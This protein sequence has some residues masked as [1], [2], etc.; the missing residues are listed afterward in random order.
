MA[1]NGVALTALGGG[2]VLLWSA[3]QN[4]KI[5]TTIQDIV[6]GQQPKPGPNQTD[7]SSTPSAGS[8]ASTGTSAG[9]TASAAPSNPSGNVALGQ[10]LAAARGWTGSEWNALYALWERESGW[11]NTARNSS[12]G[13]Y[14]IAQALGHGPTNQYPAGPANPPTSDPRA[15]IEWGLG[16]IAATYQTPSRALAHEN[17]AG[18]Y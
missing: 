12:S 15:Q 9:A 2:V 18:W 1:V 10:M 13:A 3:I 17:A 8:T 16:Y 6:K 4:Q 7:A 14:G 11:S 5:T